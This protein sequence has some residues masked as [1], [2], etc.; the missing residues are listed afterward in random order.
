[1]QKKFKDVKLHINHIIP[2]FRT[3]FISWKE[4]EGLWDLK[5]AFWAVVIIIYITS[6]QQ[7]HSGMLS[8]WWLYSG[9][10]DD[11]LLQESC[12]NVLQY[13][14]SSRSELGFGKLVKML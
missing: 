4:C 6:W 5:L 11:V 14:E 2:F 13:L 12:D 8:L 1:M 10:K 3:T 9:M 7:S